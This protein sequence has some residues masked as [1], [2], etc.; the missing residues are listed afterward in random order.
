MQEPVNGALAVVTGASRG[1]GYELA[2][3]FAQSGFNLLIASAS[4]D[5]TDAAQM[6][7]ASGATVEAVR[8]DL[9]NYA[10]VEK[11]YDAIQSKGQPVDAIA[12][13]AGVGVSGDFARDTD[14]AAELNLINLNVTSAVH[15]TKRV[16]KDMVARGQG[17][18]LF[19]SSIAAVGRYGPLRLGRSAR[20]DLRRGARCQQRL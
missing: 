19:T 5:I 14:L 20:L 13:N 12:I 18:I 2:N 17:R 9:A 8:A 10:G 4:E 1:I 11:L 15:L 3:Q 7:R 6:L 16:V